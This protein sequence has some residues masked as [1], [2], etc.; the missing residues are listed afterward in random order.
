MGRL[1]G[2]FVFGKMFLKLGFLA[3]SIFGGITLMWHISPGL[4]TLPFSAMLFVL[5]RYL[6]QVIWPLRRPTDEFP[7]PQSASDAT[8]WKKPGTS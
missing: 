6:P 2:L 8:A 7:M 1:I 4:A 5:I 3:T